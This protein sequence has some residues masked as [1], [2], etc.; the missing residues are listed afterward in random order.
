MTHRHGAGRTRKTKQS[1]R[2]PMADP[3]YLHR[4]WGLTGPDLT[5]Y[6][7]DFNTYQNR[8]KEEA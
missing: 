7:R 1:T 4:H 8:T 6:R 5:R 2:Y 3:G